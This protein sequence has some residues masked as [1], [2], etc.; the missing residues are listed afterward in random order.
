MSETKKPNE[1]VFRPA[2]ETAL[3]I[4]FGNSLDGAVN[5]AVHAFDSRLGHA[6]I[7]G[8]LETAPTIRS[9]LVRF[10]P[11]VIA[12]DVLR[13]R[14]TE[15]VAE[16]DWF[17]AAPPVNR[18]L[19]R[20]PTLYGDDAGSDLDE[21]ATTLG[22]SVSEAIEAHARVRQRVYMLG[23]APGFAYIGPLPDAWNL[24]RLTWIKPH[25]PAG[26]ICVA[27]RQTA[28]SATAIP[29]GW[30]W[31]ATTPFRSFDPRRAD[32]FLLEPG[33]EI[34]FEPIGRAMYHRLLAKADEGAAIVEREALP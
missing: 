21:T 18:G 2:G 31:I 30:R 11:L 25:V 17:Q 7:E 32:A 20:L 22:L 29:T 14:L 27:V 15:L 6:G 19:W 3:I 24:P 4:E 5:N 23:F 13:A 10:D 8:V 1:P 12:P 16:R 33:D 28:L 34:Q 9:V 26:S